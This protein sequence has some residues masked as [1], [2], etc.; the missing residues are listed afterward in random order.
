MCRYTTD[1]LLRK[2]HNA[3]YLPVWKMV[4]ISADGQ[5]VEGDVTADRTHRKCL[6]D[7]CDDRQHETRLQCLLFKL[8]RKKSLV[9]CLVIVN[10]V[11]LVKSHRRQTGALG[12]LSVCSSY[13]GP[14]SSL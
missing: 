5:E 10:I 1:F 14:I 9:S 8:E 7:K 6:V 4:L 12:D 13:H 11:K 2:S 3:R